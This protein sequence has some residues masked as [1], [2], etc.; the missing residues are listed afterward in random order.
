MEWDENNVKRKRLN[1]I[2]W[3]QIIIRWM[4]RVEL[5]HANVRIR[6]YRTRFTL[7]RYDVTEIGKSMII[8]SHIA[9]TAP[10]TRDLTP[11]LRLKR[12]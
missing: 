3:C 2:K 1:K 7:G 11:L 9:S 12:V 10:A 5:D 8:N 6:K 4:I